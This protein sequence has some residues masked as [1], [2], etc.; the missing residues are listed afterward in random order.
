MPS[1]KLNSYAK[2]N[3][4]FDIV[5]KLPDGYHRIESIMHLI[6]LCDEIEL[7]EI[8]ENK[9]KLRCDLKE[10]ENNKNLAY[11]FAM[12]LKKKFKINIG[13]EIKINKKIPIGS[14]LG[15]GSS[16]SA[17]VL[18]GLN[19]LWGLGLP[20]FALMTLASELGSDVP[21]FLLGGTAYAY[22]R[23]ESVER[24]DFNGRFM[25]LVITTDIRIDTKNAY[26]LVDIKKTGRKFATQRMLRAI[27]ENKSITEFLHN[28]FEQFIFQ[29]YPELS[30][31][32]EDLIK[33]GAENSGLTGSGSA[34]FGIFRDK[35]KLEKAYRI[36]KK[37]YKYVLITF[38]K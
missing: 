25:F 36:L 20:N 16:N 30:K 10:L 17:T 18:L 13:A 5:G 31:I 9:V 26:Q 23:G 37:L 2:L 32:K 35:G 33:N 6:D 19:K 8:K 15:G 27:N 22:N 11:K 29:K 4:T 28:D 34:V 3:L 38:S 12:L 14:G 24:V 21:F 1:I 7:S